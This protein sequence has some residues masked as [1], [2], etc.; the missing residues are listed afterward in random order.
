MYANKVAETKGK[1]ELPEV[2]KLTTIYSIGDCESLDRFRPDNSVPSKPT[3]KTF[4]YI[5]GSVKPQLI[6]K[7]NMR[8]LHKK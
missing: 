4:H 2:K 6:F 1:L 7:N 8:R 3:F 5:P